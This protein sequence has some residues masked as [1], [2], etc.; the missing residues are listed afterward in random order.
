MPQLLCT[1]LS[2]SFHI[3][4]VQ[5]WPRTFY[6]VLKT[7]R[8]LR[9]AFKKKITQ[10][11][12]LEHTGGRGLKIIHFFQLIKKETYSFGGGIKI[13]LSHVP[14]SLLCFCFHTIFSNLEALQYKKFIY[15]VCNKV[16]DLN[17]PRC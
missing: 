12:T 4:K 15:H 17:F 3:R 11:V 8:P 14:Y 16:V 1:H 10:K 7:L 2:S 6:G 13:F 5:T 9:D